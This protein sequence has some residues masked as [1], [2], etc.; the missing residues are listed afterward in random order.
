MEEKIQSVQY[1]DSEPSEFAHKPPKTQNRRWICPAF[2]GDFQP[3]GGLFDSQLTGQP[4]T[5]ANMSSW[6][7]LLLVRTSWKSVAA[8]LAS[9]RFSPVLHPQIVVAN[10]Y[11]YSD[12]NVG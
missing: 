2:R 3:L 4:F 8:S 5:I 12:W 10:S 6:S 11:T 9:P 1:R 7:V